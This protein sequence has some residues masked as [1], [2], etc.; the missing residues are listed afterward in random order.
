MLYD[1][2]HW[3][4]YNDDSLIKFKNLDKKLEF[5]KPN[6]FNDIKL[7]FENISEVALINMI[8]VQII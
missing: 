6:L 7:G 4:V 5:D 1:E 2:I 3:L 8:I